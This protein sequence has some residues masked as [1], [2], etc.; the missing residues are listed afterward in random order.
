[1][2]K[3]AINRVK[4]S[5]RITVKPWDS[6]VTLTDNKTKK[7]IKQVRASNHI[8]AVMMASAL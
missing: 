5:I 6:V 1:M 2:K 8:Q 3:Y 7:V 4:N